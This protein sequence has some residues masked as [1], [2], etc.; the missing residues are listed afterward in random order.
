[1]TFTVYIWQTYM[2]SPWIW[3]IYPLVMTNIAMENHNAINGTTHDFD[4]AIFNSYV[5]HYQ[6]VCPEELET[7]RSGKSMRNLGFIR[8]EILSLSMGNG[9][10]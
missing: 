7:W 4:W 1:M 6:K 9:G 3:L 8:W 10:F 2:D 5:S